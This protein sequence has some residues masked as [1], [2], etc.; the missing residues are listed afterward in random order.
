MEY[1]D[2]LEVCYYEMYKDYKLT[3]D[4][5]RKIISDLDI[6][7]IVIKYYED[8][9]KEKEDRLLADAEYNEKHYADGWSD[10]V[11]V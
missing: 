10:H 11:G 8:A 2:K 4:Q 7:D 9:I 3:P 5:A 1:Q 6:E